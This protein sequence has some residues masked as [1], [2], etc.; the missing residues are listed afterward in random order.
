MIEKHLR[1]EHSQTAYTHGTFSHAHGQRAWYHVIIF[2]KKAAHEP[3]ASD[4]AC[5]FISL[6]S[7]WRYKEFRNGS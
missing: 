1:S 2:T 3:E 5:S 4:S 7:L 6:L